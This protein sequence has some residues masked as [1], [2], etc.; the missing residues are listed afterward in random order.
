MLSWKTLTGWSYQER[1]FLL[2]R[3]QYSLHIYYGGHQ[4]MI[5]NNKQGKPLQTCAFNEISTV[6]VFLMKRI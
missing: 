5:Q 6:L 3:L 2:Q 1:D 4:I